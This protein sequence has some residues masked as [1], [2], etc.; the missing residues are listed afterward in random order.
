MDKGNNSDIYKAAGIIIKKRKLLVEKDFYKEFFISPG[1]KLE[2]G[3]TPKEALVREL[4]E[5]FE[6]IVE[7]DDLQEFGHYHAKASGQEHRVIHMH[8]FVVKKYSGKIREGHKVEKLLWLNSNIPE[9]IKVG[10]I[11]EH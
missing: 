7:E 6:I 11:F 10:S 1:G 5:E 4:N 9:G 2:P 3:E 8:V